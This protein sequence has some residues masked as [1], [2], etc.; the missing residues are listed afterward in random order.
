[1]SHPTTLV[2]RA[3]R[4]RGAVW[5]CCS[6]TKRSRKNPRYPRHAASRRSCSA[7]LHRQIPAVSRCFHGLDVVATEARVWC[8]RGPL[9]IFFCPVA[10]GCVHQLPSP[11]GSLFPER[12]FSRGRVLETPRLR[13]RCLWQCWSFQRCL[14]EGRGAGFFGRPHRHPYRL[15]HLH[16]ARAIERARWRTRARVR[17]TRIRRGGPTFGRCSRAL[18]SRAQLFLAEPSGY[19]LHDYGGAFRTS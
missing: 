13:P 17:C 16:R 8:L 10:I 11:I 7:C 19:S 15:R 3:A 14:F 5:P 12:P 6:C 2:D 18:L 4:A 1:M 9:G